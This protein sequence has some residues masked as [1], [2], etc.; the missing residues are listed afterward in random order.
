MANIIKELLDAYRVNRDFQK[1]IRETY[2]NSIKEVLSSLYDTGVR[3]IY[4]GSLAK[5]TANT[6]SCD[7]DLICYVNCNTNMTLKE[8]YETTAKALEDN[9]YL[10]NRKN[11]AI[12][13]TGKIGEN[14]WDTTVDVV[15]GRYIKDSQDVNLWNNREQKTLKTNPEKQINKVKESNSKDL[16]RIVKLFREFN[17][18]RFK[19]FFLEIFIIDIV[20]EDFQDGDDIQDKLVH[21]CNHSNDIGTT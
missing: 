13:L 21:F 16:I 8:I 12:E 14:S 1:E 18:L 20:E 9:N 6:N 17:N 2:R 3:F 15:P 7:I 10:V 4:G 5:G 11:S 19:S